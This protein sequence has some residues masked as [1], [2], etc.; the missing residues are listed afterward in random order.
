MRS[1]KQFSLQA[2]SAQPSTQ[3]TVEF[4][5]LPRARRLVPV[6]ALAWSGTFN[7][8]YD[9]SLDTTAAEIPFTGGELSLVLMLPGKISEFVTGIHTNKAFTKMECFVRPDLNFILRWS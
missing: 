1:D 4:I 5:N 7:A 2:D 3:T 8:G 6:S 9:P